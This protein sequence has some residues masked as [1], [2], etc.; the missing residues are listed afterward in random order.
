MSCLTLL[1]RFPTT[2]VLPH[3]SAP[4][5]IFRSFRRALY[6]LEPP[7]PRDGAALPIGATLISLINARRGAPAGGCGG[8]GE[9]E[10]RAQGCG[11]RRR[12]P[13]GREDSEHSGSVCR[14]NSRGKIPGCDILSSR[15]SARWGPRRPTSQRSWRSL[16]PDMTVEEC[17][18]AR[19]RP[20]TAWIFL[21][22]LR[23]F[24]ETFA[25]KR[26][27]ASADPGSACDRISSK[28]RCN[29]PCHSPRADSWFVVGGPECS[30][31]H[32]WPS[33]FCSAGALL[34][35]VG[36]SRGHPPSSTQ[37]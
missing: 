17:P 19:A 26:R 2:A 13:N 25:F 1:A 31:D 29:L 33:Q 22:N 10:E 3:R 9:A 6:R 12:A 34:R 24:A 30:R 11:W 21:V 20:A 27:S 8:E 5:S 7:H 35:G 15:R 4:L 28:R 32:S 23:N 36:G 18:R 16:A 37:P 14:A